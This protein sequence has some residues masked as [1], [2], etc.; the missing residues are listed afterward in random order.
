MTKH[1]V[2]HVFENLTSIIA[3]CFESPI[4]TAESCTSCGR[5]AAEF[6]FV[7]F[8]GIGSYDMP[9]IH[10][11]A[12]HSFYI[13]DIETLGVERR[14]KKGV[15]VAHKFGM[16]AGT[17]CLI[18][19]NGKVTVFSPKGTFDKLPVS[20]LERFEVIECTSYEQIGHL[21][22]MKL[23]FPLVYIEDFG[24]KTTDLI[25]GLRWS[26]SRN[27]IIVCTDE[28]NTSITESMN[29]L[30][31]DCLADIA[32]S[33]NKVPFS[34]WNKFKS[35]LAKLYSGNVSP[36]GFTDSLKKLASGDGARL[37]DIYRKFPTDPH[38]RKMM[39]KKIDKVKTALGG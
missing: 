13:G 6:G 4:E 20:F 32:V 3:H 12:C 27:K 33:S 24:K 29:T 23:N 26:Y 37:I 31:L 8:E 21:V 16:M 35:E 10:C 2:S 30:D 18:Q 5:P 1:P 11:S 15:S 36:L 14:S 9:Y 22:K 28:G 38:V 7:G 39:I 34:L 25:T 17:G 19:S